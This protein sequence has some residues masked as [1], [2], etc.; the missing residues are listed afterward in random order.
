MTVAKSP[1]LEVSA[2][3]TTVSTVNPGDKINVSWQVGNVGGLPTEAGWNEQ[4]YLDGE[5]GS[6]KLLSTTYYE[7]ALN[8][9]GIV[10]RSAE[11]TVPQ[12]LSVDGIAT[13]RVKLTPD[14][15]A[16]ERRGCVKTMMRQHKRQSQ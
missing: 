15:K 12:I 13:I 7:N 11:I 9:G 4:I 6:S 8:A 16:G 1:D 5:N 14:S 10:S 3:S 2:V